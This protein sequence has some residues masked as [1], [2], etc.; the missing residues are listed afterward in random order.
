[1]T[2]GVFNALTEQELSAALEC[3]AEE[4][5]RSIEQWICEKGYRNQDNYTAVI[6]QCCTATDQT[7]SG[8][9]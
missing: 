3:N 9:E 8:K 7:A 1:M 4:A 6:L 5:A 2:D